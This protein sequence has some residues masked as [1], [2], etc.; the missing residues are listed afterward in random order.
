MKIEYKHEFNVIRNDNKAYGNKIRTKLLIY[1]NNSYN[2]TSGF[3]LTIHN[4]LTERV[5]FYNREEN[6]VL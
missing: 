1:V 4:G 5:Q 6:N 2:H 3:Y